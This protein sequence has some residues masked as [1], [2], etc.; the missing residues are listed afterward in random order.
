MGT[1]RSFLAHRLNLEWDLWLTATERIHMFT[2]PFQRGGNFMRLEFDGDDVSYSEELEFFNEDTDTLFFEGD[3]GQIIGGVTGRYAPFDMPIAFGLVPLL[4]QNGVW[5]EDQFLG[6]AATIPAQNS[7]WR[8][9]SNYDVTFFAGFDQVSSPAFGVANPGANLFGV[10]TFI[11]RRGGY[12]EVGYA[13]VDDT[14]TLGGS[15]HNLGV[16]YTRRYLNLVSNSVRVIVN[17][18]QQGLQS[19]RTADGYLVIMENSFLTPLPYNVIPYVNLWAGFDNP[20][21]ASRAAAAGGV[22]R[23]VGILFESDNLTGYPTLDATANNT[24]GAAFGIDVLAMD[25]SQ[26]LILEAAYLHAFDSAVTRNAPGDQ[27]GLGARYQ[28]PISHA[29]LIRL[30]AMFGWLENTGDVAGARAEFR[31]KF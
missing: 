13:Y 24:V 11:E 1:D 30:D 6:A 17:A 28:I 12:I 14:G 15:Y 25:F 18:G 16:S 22:L 8:D 2:G 19:T 29:T 5:M 10:T 4:F 26:Q 3:L 21:S 23:N 31:W 9:W 7:P 27:Y 20:Q